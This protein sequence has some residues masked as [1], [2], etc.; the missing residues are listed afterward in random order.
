MKK[1]LIA[2]ILLF[3]LGVGGY[4]IFDLL[5]G[6]RPIAL[7]LVEASPETLAGKTFKGT[8][9]DKKLEKAFSSVESLQSLHPETSLHTLYYVEP[10]GKLDT[11][12]VFAGINLPFGA[13]G[14]EIKKFTESRYILAKV[15]SNKWVMPS[16]ESIKAQIQDYAKAKNL[17]LSGY[18]IDK[19]ISETEVHVLAPVR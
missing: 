5:G 10:A 8:P 17:T 15:S 12:E 9:L 7:S 2:A 3:V 14:M 16:P 1:L 6:N 19:I 18:Y 11:L 4:F 13:P